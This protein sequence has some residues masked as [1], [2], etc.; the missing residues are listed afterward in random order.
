MTGAVI[1]ITIFTKGAGLGVLT[2]RIKLGSDGKPET[3]NSECKMSSGKAR[4]ARISDLDGLAAVIENL[5]KIEAIAIGR[6]RPKIGDKVIG[7]EVDIVVKDVEAAAN[8]DA[9]GCAKAIAR[10]KINFVFEPGLPAPCLLDHDAKTMPPSVAETFAAAGGFWPALV[11][12]CP[13]LASAARLTRS[14]TSAGLS[15]SDTG[16]TFPSSGGLHVYLLIKDGSDIERFLDDLEARCWLAGLGWITFS[17]AGSYLVRSIIDVAVGRP[18][19][20]CFEAPAIIEAP[21][22]QDPVAR[23]PVVTPGVTI[24]SYAACPPL[25]TV[26]RAEVRRL[27]ENAKRALADER[28]RIL[29]ARAGKI[30]NQRGITIDAARRIVDDQCNGLLISDHVLEFDDPDIIRPTTVGD[31]LDDPTKYEGQTLA[32][33]NEGIAYGPCKAKVMIDGEGA[34]WIHSF[35][36]GRTIY[37]LKYTAA[38]V[39]ERIERATGDVLAC[40]ISLVL[41]ADPSRLE[42]DDLIEIVAQRTSRKSS[43]IKAAVKE[44]QREQAERRRAE[45]RE[46]KRAERNDRR[47]EMSRPRADAPLTEEMAKINAAITGAPIE[48]QLRRN[49][50][51]SAVK[52]RCQPVPNTHAFS[53]D[54]KEEAPDQWTIAILREYGLTEEIERFINYV[55]GGGEPVRP[56]MP[57]VQ[58]YMNRDDQA[59]HILAA[60]ST[61]P[62]VLAD[63]V[64]LGRE[65]GF[66]R[67]RGIQF[68]VPESIVA[69]VPQ[70][71][72]CTPEAVE[73]AMR[74]VTDEWLCDVEADY[75]VKCVIIAAALT[76][77]ERSLL[78]DRPVF[79]VTAGRRG[80]GKTTTIIM[81]IKALSGAW[82]AASAWS[83]KEDERRKAI[84]S[85]FMLGVPYILWD[86]I[87]RGFQ[88]SCPHVERSCSISLYADRKL[89]VSEIVATA[90]TSIHFFTGNNI[91]PRGDMSS[92]SLMI[93]LKTD[94]PDPENRKFKHPHP[95]AW[96][97]AN[98]GEIFQ[99]L[100]TI[101]LGNPIL[102]EPRDAAMKTRFK[103]WYRLIGSAVENAAKQTGNAIDFEKLFAEQDEDDEDDASL[104]SV[105]VEIAGWAKNLAANIG[106][107]NGKALFKANDLCVNLN[108]TTTTTWDDPLRDA[109]RTFFYPTF[110]ADDRVSPVSLGRRLM[111]HVDE[112]VRGGEGTLILRKEKGDGSANAPLVYWVETIAT[113]Q[114]GDGREKGDGG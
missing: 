64:V 105:L 101:M 42:L 33:P 114:D 55:D 92:R 76:V 47:P 113:A 34:P 104:A 73:K 58:A 100:Y 103:M 28:N 48:Q 94:R 110:K 57:L 30:A 2:K 29:V 53:I 99:A 23:R 9:V 36:H 80:S 11:G 75:A 12:A 98:R 87:P 35:A 46:R 65:N 67:T 88:V 41:R 91:A 52:L 50:Y 15:R 32:D 85:Q 17:A 25:T 1:E 79:F 71:E 109:A 78:P 22:A 86:N 63:G 26:E 24:D 108:S 37:R 18:E 83:P 90:A 45:A 16:E 8:R 102:S 7:D 97:D 89:G 72:D 66:D 43:Q 69:L 106:A 13:G 6:M 74:F 111:K 107:T 96:T 59:L 54:D 61:Q 70:R 3:D 82:P 62:I 68:I 20:L 112:P 44:A 40:F 21:L 60:I 27:Q 19:R 77:I 49:L 81:L 10:S 56:P 4:R 51:G 5:K 31:L 14:S 95:V 38:A 84:L 39:K 93:R